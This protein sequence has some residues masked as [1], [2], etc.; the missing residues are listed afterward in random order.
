MKDV[1]LL[2][3]CFEI[4]PDSR[5][6]IST[7]VY[8]NRTTNSIDSVSYHY[9]PKL[10]CKPSEEVIFDSYQELQEWL[11]GVVQP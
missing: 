11:Y 4:L 5:G 7:F 9:S 6:Y 8:F 1:I 3:K 2:S 10:Y